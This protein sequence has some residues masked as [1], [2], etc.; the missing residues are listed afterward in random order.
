MITTMDV[1]CDV[2]ESYGNFVRGAD[3]ELIPYISSANVACGFH[4]GDP[5]HMDRTVRLAKQHG[6]SIGVH[7][8]LPDINGFGRRRID[9]S[10]EE[11]RAMTLYQIGALRAFADAHNVPI[12]HLLPHGVLYSMLA[13]EG[14]ARAV[15][16]AI[17]ETLADRVLYWPTPLQE[18][19]FYQI[20][21]RQGLRVV[22]ALTIDLD[23]RADGSLVVERIKQPRDPGALADRLRRFIELGRLATIDGTDLEF[24]AQALVFHSDGPNALDIARSIRRTLDAMGISVAPAIQAGGPA[25]RQAERGG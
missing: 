23:Y 15:L 5:V 2:G 17:T 13:E 11:A 12:G 7:F 16:P 1:S 20:A 21:R 18:H 6:V 8:G 24:E 25:R 4:A 3:E 22:A 14:L 9:I 19:A 10:A